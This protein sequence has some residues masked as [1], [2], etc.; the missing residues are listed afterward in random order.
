MS[1]SGRVATESGMTLVELLIA[2]AI[3]GII[4]APLIGATIVSLNIGQSATQRVTDTSGA[5]LTSS[6]FVSDVEGSDQVITPPA[7][8][9]CGG[10]NTLVELGW[11]D[12]DP[13]SA[14]MTHITYD[15]VPPAGGTGDY[16]IVRSVYSVSAGG[17]CSLTS[18]STVVDATVSPLAPNHPVVSCAPTSSPCGAGSQA[19]S[20]QITALTSQTSSNSY[21]PY[22]FLL[23]GTRR[24]AT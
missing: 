2:V 18:E 12:A 3:L 22:T 16:R 10:A 9:K 13:S 24:A 19:V 21:G 20:L 1:R 8:M 11:T 15:D 23:T 5:Q 6:W 17:S 7:A 14:S 4:I